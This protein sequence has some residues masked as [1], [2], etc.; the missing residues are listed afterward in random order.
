MFGAKATPTARGLYGF[1]PVLTAM[2]LGTEVEQ[3]S[4]RATLCRAEVLRLEGGLADTR[5]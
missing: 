3:P 4:F 5:T 2:A 1:S